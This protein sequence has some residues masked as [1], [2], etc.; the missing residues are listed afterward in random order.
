MRRLA[1]RSQ[2]VV[3]LGL[4]GCVDSD[5]ERRRHAGEE[6]FERRGQES[7]SSSMG[8]AR[9]RAAWL[10]SLIARCWGPALSLAVSYRA[11]MEKGE[12]RRDGFV[13]VP[14]C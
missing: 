10:K 9:E 7:F 3:A 13:C 2:R 5:C 14:G 12:L 11:E 4:R 8:R 1:L 6:L